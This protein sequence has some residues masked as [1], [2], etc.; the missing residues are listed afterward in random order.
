MT[1]CFR[2]GAKRSEEQKKRRRI[3]TGNIQ[4]EFQKIILNRPREGRR[5]LIFRSTKIPSFHEPRLA[6]G[7]REAG[8]CCRES[9]SVGLQRF[10]GCFRLKLAVNVRRRLASD[11]T[12][13]VACPDLTSH[14]W[15]V[16][17]YSVDLDLEIISSR[18]LLTS[19]PQQR[20]GI[21]HLPIS[22]SLIL[23]RT[24]GN[25][26]VLLYPPYRALAVENIHPFLGEEKPVSN[27][28][29][30]CMAL[31]LKYF[32]NCF[33]SWSP[34][35]RHATVHI[36][37]PPSIPMQCQTQTATNVSVYAQTSSLLAWP[38]RPGPPAAIP[39]A[40]VARNGKLQPPLKSS[41]GSRKR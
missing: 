32:F 37:N 16:R 28:H 23:D 12:S 29:L 27:T 3:E 21:H 1:M 30:K 35:L 11:I 13:S 22:R 19:C 39:S 6:C 34:H 4:K 7:N 5:R 17:S 2:T 41:R 36:H 18:M 31:E 15:R 14:S 40:T 38:S 25:S 9:P 20:L 8:L 10:P 33:L 26:W 24:V